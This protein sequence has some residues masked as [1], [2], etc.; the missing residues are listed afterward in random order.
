MSASRV[1]PQ[2]PKSA[3]N[4]AG[5][6]PIL[7]PD[8]DAL[9]LESRRR[10]LIGLS[11]FAL[12]VIWGSTY[13]A[14]KISLTGYAPFAMGAIRMVGAGVVLLAWLK[15]RGTPW[16]TAMQW[17]NCA[18]AGVLLLCFGNGLVGYA[19]L[20]VSSSLAAVAVAAMPLYA[21]FFAG[22]TGQWPARRD[23]YG[24]AL[25]FTGV[26]LLNLGGEL[27]ASP[28]GALALVAAPMAWA[29]GSVW[30]RGR[31]LPDPWMNTALQMVIG[32]IA[33]GLVSLALG[34]AWPESPPWQATAALAYLA[35]FGSLVAFTAYLYLLRTVRPALATSYAY[36][37]PP[38]AVLLGVLLAG[39][40]V[41]GFEIAAM[42]V[43]VAGV[44]VI[45]RNRT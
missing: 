20:T 41:G 17:R 45:L 39:E 32:G 2:R 12:Y 16:P 30:S 19:E 7:R 27:R 5:D 34:E 33:Q 31:D 11:L 21:A 22:L 42:V 14:I 36:V 6:S 9:A 25:G 26:V 10:W 15:L 23:A 24:L 3:P 8:M 43:V 35:V 13:L 18:I 4:G 1:E 40:S 29:Y 37:N 28:L 38:V 44:A